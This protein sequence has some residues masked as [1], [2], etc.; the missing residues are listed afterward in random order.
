VQAAEIVQLGEPEAGGVDRR[1]GALGGGRPSTLGGLAG[2]DPLDDVRRRRRSGA[3]ERQPRPLHRVT[4]GNDVPDRCIDV[5]HDGDATVRKAVPLRR[6][7]D[8]RKGPFRA[9]ESI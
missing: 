5:D 1:N 2:R 6:I 7:D 8:C 3:Q 4:V 9:G